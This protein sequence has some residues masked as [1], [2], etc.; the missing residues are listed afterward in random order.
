MKPVLL[1][2]IIIVQL[3]LLCYTIGIITEQ[4]KRVINLVVITFLTLGVSFDITATAGMIIGSENSPF[5]LH[6]LLGYSS[7]IGMLIDVSL[8]WRH[9]LQK[10][11]EAEVS[12]KLHL[13]SRY[14]YAWWVAAYITGAVLVA[15]GRG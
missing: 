3:A 11:G 13:Y 15:A 4:R 12:P 2:G 9:R 5:T 1:A 10:G 7:L 6:G 8:A 14:A